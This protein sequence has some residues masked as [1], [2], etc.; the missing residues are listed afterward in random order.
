LARYSWPGNV[1]ELQNVIERAVINANN[2][3]LRFD[4]LVSPRMGAT[5]PLTNEA[6]ARAKPKG[7]IL[8]RSDL[9]QLEIENLEGAIAAADGKIYGPHGAAEL[10]GVRP[11]TLA[12]RMR[13]LGINKP[14]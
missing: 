4:G 10:L 7:N 13:K 3:Q 11:T 2:G 9:I 6:K 14:R 8:S 5:Q 1:R 12:S